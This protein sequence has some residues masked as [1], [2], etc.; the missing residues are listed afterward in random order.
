MRPLTDNPISDFGDDAFRFEPYVD[1]LHGAVEQAMPL[2]LTVGVFGSWGTGK[3]SFLRLWQRRLEDRKVRTIWFNPWKYDRK[4]EVWAALLHTILAEMEGEEGLKEKALRLAKAATWLSVR[5]GLGTAAS[6]ATGGMIKSGDVDSL[7]TTLSQGDAEQY[8]QINR[9]ENDFRDA[10]REFVGADGRLV[11][12]V[13]DLDR[14]TPDSAMTVLESLKLFLGESQCV[15]VLALDLDVLAAVATNKF[16]DAFKDAP[17]EV[18]SG[19]AYLDKIVQLPFFLPDVGFDTLRE[20]FTPYVHQP[21]DD[22][23]FWELLRRGLG[24]NPRRLKRFVNVFNMAMEVSIAQAGGASLDRAF[25][26]QL[27]VLQ[28]IRSRH[29]AFFHVLAAEPRSW[30]TLAGYFR[31][32]QDDPAERPRLLSGLPSELHLFGADRALERLL[33]QR[34]S[35]RV[36]PPTP[37]TVRAMIT[38]LRATAG[39]D[40]LG[41]ADD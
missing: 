27:A 5:T 20:A 11:V 1:V 13:D 23:A 10:V 4:V 39:P 14:C 12:F 38:T 7:L 17:A 36:P 19:L 35:L 16:G 2:P 37:Q 18:V 29:R 6:A 21:I 33:T 30:D 26:L 34:G 24:A 31:Q 25:H 3:S 9:F 40:G 22:D 41:S 32:V 28:M 8:R 15:F